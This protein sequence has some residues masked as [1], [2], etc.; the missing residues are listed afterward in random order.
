M[1]LTIFTDFLRSDSKHELNIS[2]K[3]KKIVSENLNQDEVDSNIFDRIQ[4]EIE[5]L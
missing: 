4:D 2:L 1:A 3:M 5:Y